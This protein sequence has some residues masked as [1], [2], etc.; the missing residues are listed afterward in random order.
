MNDAVQPATATESLSEGGVESSLE[1]LFG[2]QQEP[3]EKKAPEEA[4]ESD[5]DPSELDA[6]DLP[7]NEDEET[8]APNADE[9]EI[10]HNGQTHKLSRNELIEYGRKGFDYTQKTMAVA[11]TQRQYSE[12]L[13]ALAQ[14]EQVQPML[15]QELAQVTA[16]H[17]QLQNGR[18][19][20]QEMLRLA[21]E[22]FIEHAQRNEERNILRNQLQ[23]AAGQYQQKTQAVQQYVSQLSQFQLDQE[24]ARLPELI[25]A[26]K[27]EDRMKADKADIAQYLQKAGADMRGIGKYLDNALAMKI[28]LQSMK[29]ERL[30]QSKADKSKQVRT[31]PPVVKPGANVPSDKGRSVF[32]KARGEIRKAGQQGRHNDQEKMME[33]LLG[34]AFK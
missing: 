5:A 2:T 11:D 32:Q 19:S 13:Q 23:Q 24:A 21:R 12:R 22:D 3:P 18:Y 28:V 6:S 8:Q 20:D 16:L 10:V 26:W 4:V 7:E 17:Q 31:A 14:V 1:N 9:Y 27:S 15:A 34:R 25:P 30:Q 33:S 29:Y